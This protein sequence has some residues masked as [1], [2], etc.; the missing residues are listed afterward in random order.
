MKPEQF[1]LHAAIEAEHWWFAARR[2]II[3]QVIQQL[4]PPSKEVTIADV[5]C[6][7]GGNISG[8]AGLYSCLGIDTSEEA[9]ELARAKFPDVTFICGKAPGRLGARKDSVDIFLLL[10]VLEHVEFDRDFFL[11]LFAVLKPGGHI[12]LTVPAKM[13]LWSPQDVNYGHYRRY[14]PAQLEG[15]WSGLPVTVRLFSFFNTYLYPLV[16]G[17]RVF[18]RLRG[19]EWGE[20]GTDL[21]LPPRSL[22]RMLQ[23]I[24]SWEAKALTK[25]MSSGRKSGFS[26][27]VSLMA[28]LRKDV[29]REWTKS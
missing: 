28:C 8:L 4:V 15:L 1:H 19:R 18:N 27:G 13:S 21:S 11:E 3:V 24:Y 12:L 17:V 6:G 2:A 20:A 25:M 5:G 16:K 14:E 9:I 10:D 29:K 26:F 22:N 23:A 7:T